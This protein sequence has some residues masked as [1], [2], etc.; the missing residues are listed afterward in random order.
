MLTIRGAY[1][2]FAAPDIDAERAFYANRLGITVHEGM[3]NLMLDLPGGG[4]VLIY[5][6]PDHQPATFTVLNLEVADI[7]AAVDELGA[8]GIEMDATKVSNRTSGGSS[9]TR[10]TRSHVQGPRRQHPVGGLGR[11]SATAR[12]GQASRPARMVPVTADA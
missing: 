8:A 9:A 5:P 12:P 2:G 4:R 11:L 7:D 1:A 6:K 3:G 10:A